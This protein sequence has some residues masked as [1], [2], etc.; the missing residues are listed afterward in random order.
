MFSK[1]SKNIQNPREI[2][3]ISHSSVTSTSTYS[4]SSDSSLSNGHQ[5]L[6]QARWRGA[7]PKQQSIH[8]RPNRRQSRAT[9]PSQ[10]RTY[11]RLSPM[12]THIYTLLRCRLRRAFLLAVRSLRQQAHTAS[13]P[14]CSQAKRVNSGFRTKYCSCPRGTPLRLI[15]RSKSA[16]GRLKSWNPSGNGILACWMISA[17]SFTT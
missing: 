11:K 10:L 13:A 1:S 15:P 6:R 17:A 12:T 4:S 9:Q 7:I 16:I 2:R 5:A 14:F 8:F 3:D